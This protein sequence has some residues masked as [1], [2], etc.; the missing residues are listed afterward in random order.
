MGDRGDEGVLEVVKEVVWERECRD[1]SERESQS[2][3]PKKASNTLTARPFYNQH[4]EK[5]YIIYII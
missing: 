4:K 1:G 3:R 2:I 5:G